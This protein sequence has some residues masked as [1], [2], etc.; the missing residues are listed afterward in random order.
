MDEIIPE[1]SL[2][3]AE[4]SLRWSM[5]SD[6]PPNR[7][8]F[9]KPRSP[10]I[11]G[12]ASPHNNPHP[13]TPGFPITRTGKNRV[14]VP[15]S[16]VSDASTPKP[17][18]A[19]RPSN[20]LPNSGFQT[21]IPG[22]SVDVQED[23]FTTTTRCTFSPSPL[24]APTST[25]PLTLPNG[26]MEY[27]VS[28]VP[29]V[30][31]E[32]TP[33]VSRLQRTATT[34]P[35][36]LLNLQGLRKSLSSD[37][38]NI[39]SRHERN[40]DNKGKESPQLHRAHIETPS[41]QILSGL[42]SQEIQNN[43]CPK[44]SSLNKSTVEREDR[45]MVDE[46]SA[47]K[48]LQIVN[49]PVNSLASQKGADKRS[50][51][52]PDN[53]TSQQVEE[54]LKKGES[55]V[56]VAEGEK[57]GK[58][59]DT[60]KMEKA[61]KAAERK[62]EEVQKIEATRM[63]EKARNLEDTRGEDGARKVE[64]VQNLEEAQRVGGKRKV[65]V[66]GN[67]EV[68][69][70]KKD[71]EQKTKVQ[72]ANNEKLQVKEQRTREKKTEEIKN[73]VEAEKKG[74]E[75][76][77]TKAGVAAEKQGEELKKI[78]KEMKAKG[79]AEETEGKRHEKLAKQKKNQLEAGSK[80]AKTTVMREAESDSIQKSDVAPPTE[81]LPASQVGRKR[82]ISESPLTLE[83]GGGK[84]QKVTKTSEKDE[85]IPKTASAP[86]KK[87]TLVAKPRRSV[88]FADVD[89]PVLPA[90]GPDVSE[91]STAQKTSIPM[92]VP[93]P[94]LSQAAK[95]AAKK[96]KMEAKEIMALSGRRRS[97]L[98][99]EI[100]ESSG[101]DSEVAQQTSER[102]NS[103]PMKVSRRPVDPMKP[104]SDPKQEANKGLNSGPRAESESESESEPESEFES[105]SES[106]SE[107]GSEYKSV[108]KENRII[109]MND[110]ATEK[111]STLKTNEHVT[112]VTKGSV[113]C[114][115]L[116]KRQFA[117]RTA[118]RIST[119]FSVVKETGTRHSTKNT[120]HDKETKEA[121]ASRL[122]KTLDG[123]HNRPRHCLQILDLTEIQIQP[124]LVLSLTQILHLQLVP[125]PKQILHL[126]DNQELPHEMTKLQHE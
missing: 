49:T 14:D 82:Q 94:K 115:V 50:Q 19:P 53:Q 21:L 17:K 112:G 60:R 86:S 42:V 75:A 5:N 8:L 104:S 79:K 12:N 15:C 83:K 122:Q 99:K 90:Q 123:K 63:V 78:G 84:K 20:L 69:N 2:I 113:S 33:K 111:E 101:S 110:A 55:K 71:Q 92:P 103:T 43:S 23:E 106:E 73:T 109:E 9:G 29:S 68:R 54:N 47:Q 48:G 102:I 89:Q 100:V 30:P 125:S 121:T 70:V 87:S 114:D 39:S 80:R 7:S 59:A 93:L 61:R 65:E 124:Q 98:S 16:Q 31:T 85:H 97:K 45:A 27:S 1:S 57:A 46:A 72:K 4:D 64:E 117:R 37:P 126:H 77:R 52:V 91:N 108:L 118:S 35:K 36:E 56:A 25:V 116:P 66:S 74:A 95:P 62:T 41:A 34:Q 105:E 81:E 40:E 107:L 3:G 22:P 11:E 96:A 24:S 6:L 44:T 10:S 32:L 26:T 51:G 28:F 18:G 76:A 67:D 88:S 58:L 120:L 38:S 119:P 13:E